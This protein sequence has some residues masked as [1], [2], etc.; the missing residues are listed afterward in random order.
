MSE[1]KPKSSPL[2]VFIFLI[3]FFFLVFSFPFGSLSFSSTRAKRISSTANLKQI[4]QALR[5]Y[6]E[7]SENFFPNSPGAAGLK[8]LIDHN[9]LTDYK[10]YIMPIDRQ[11]QTPTAGTFLEPNISY[12][13]LGSG[14]QDQ[15][16]QLAEKIPLAFEKPWIDKGHI[17]ILYMEGYVQYLEKVKFET[18]VDVVEFCRKGNN[19]D[20][21]YWQTLL[22]NAR[23]IDKT[24]PK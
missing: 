7:D 10:T 5:Q 2:A 6:L 8:M 18:C 20:A 3:V 12:A 24:N 14:L 21:P 23:L 11:A 17:S 16:L 13:Y 1:K 4:N 19:P 15:P 9:Y 22:A